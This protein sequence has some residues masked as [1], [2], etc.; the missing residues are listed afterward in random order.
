M[1]HANEPEI[2]EDGSVYDLLV[3]GAGPNGLACAMEAVK[4]GFI[5]DATSGCMLARERARY[6]RGE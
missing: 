5:W 2:A 3:V 6:E 1:S 4:A